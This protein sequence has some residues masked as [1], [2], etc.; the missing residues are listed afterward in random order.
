MK[1]LLIINKVDELIAEEGT[2]LKEKYGN[3]TL[4]LSEENYE[5][6][7]S[8]KSKKQT[9][10]NRFFSYFL[11]IEEINFSNIIIENYKS[12][13]DIN[14]KFK[15][16]KQINLLVKNH[17]MDKIKY[18]ADKYNLTITQII[19]FMLSYKIEVRYEDK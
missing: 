12:I 6:L 9:V 7:Q 13:N 11:E 3:Y 16:A 19:N 4:K 8:L 15:N 5:I 2:I 18:M 14:L 10:I 1:N 17:Y